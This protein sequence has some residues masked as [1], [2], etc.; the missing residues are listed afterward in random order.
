[1]R[2]SI[3]FWAVLIFNGLNADRFLNNA[4]SSYILRF[5]SKDAMILPD[6]KPS[7]WRITTVEGQCNHD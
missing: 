7:L 4:E 5:I 1:M 6:G 3:T 2:T